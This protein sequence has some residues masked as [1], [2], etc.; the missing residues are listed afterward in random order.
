MQTGG[1][2]TQPD[3]RNIL[4]LPNDDEMMRALESAGAMNSVP[5]L[6]RSSHLKNI[7]TGVVM[8]WNPLLAE[9]RD[10]MVNC[11]RTGNTDPAAWASTVVDEELAA[12]EQEK[13]YWEARQSIVTQAMHM[14]DRYKTSNMETNIPQGNH[15]IPDDVKP[16]HD[17]TDELDNL[18]RQLEY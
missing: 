2:I 12:S 8:P 14:S 11:D 1:Y 5:P 3:P 13:L 9:Q 18:R 6:Q 4:N 10:I 16:Y 17:Y 15:R 7:Q